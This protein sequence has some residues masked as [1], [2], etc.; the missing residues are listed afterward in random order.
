[1]PFVEWLLALSL[2][3]NLLIFVL[4]IQQ[5]R[6][7]SKK[8]HHLF[9]NNIEMQSNQEDDRKVPKLILQTC[10]DPTKVPTKVAD[11]FKRFAP[12]YERRVYSENEAI[13]FL[14][15]YF[16]FSV[17]HKFLD[18]RVGA[19]KADLLRYCLLYI[20]GG[21]YMDIKTE[22]I[23]PIDNMFQDG[24]ITTAFTKGTRRV[25]QGV[26]GAPPKQLIFLELIT[27]ILERGDSPVYLKFTRDFYRFI[28]KDVGGVRE[29]Y[30]QGKVHNYMIFTEFLSR[31]AKECYDG[32]D[33]R[34]VCSNIIFNNE[35][36]IKTRYA[37]Y[38]WK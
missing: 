27:L 4:V 10:H 8:H 37:D 30:L 23:K 29:G 24:V 1:M 34:G 21:I 19:H 13:Q 14:R 36:I 32:L 18:L 6:R 20:Y 22:L 7:R 12:D 38:P 31:N 17:V 35:R 16:S 2:I 3:L 9:N 25:Y 28:K 33:Q 11:N 15:R 5:N 26:I